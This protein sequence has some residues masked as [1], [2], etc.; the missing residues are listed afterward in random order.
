MESNREDARQALLAASRAEAAPYIHYPATPVWFAPATGLWSAAMV[1]VW[2]WLPDS[3][4]LLFASLAILLALEAAAIT[5][6]QRSHGALPMPGTGTPPAEIGRVWRGYFCGC[7]AVLVV[8]ALAWIVVGILAAA[9]TA[10]VLVT[11]GLY[12]YDSAYNT[13]AKSV[14]ARLA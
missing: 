4:A 7:A 8:V 6:L 3:K 10:F 2:A 5:W 13:A 12:W 14:R 9:I 1:G 11:A